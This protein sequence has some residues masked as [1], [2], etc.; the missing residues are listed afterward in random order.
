MVL[1]CSHTVFHQ[2]H[3]SHDKAKKSDDKIQEKDDNHDYQHPG[4]R[5][6]AWIASVQQESSSPSV[7]STGIEYYLSIEYYRVVE[8]EQIQLGVIP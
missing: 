3:V 6:I 1:S 2:A 5:I 8:Q 4:I 7:N